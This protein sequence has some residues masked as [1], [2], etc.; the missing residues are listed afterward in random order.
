MIP[1]HFVAIPVIPLLP[2]GKIDR[3]AFP[4]PAAQPDVTLA[5]GTMPSTPAEIA[6]AAIWQ[7]LLGVSSVSATD[8]FFELGGHSLLAVRA[9]AEIEAELHVR[10]SP[11]QFIFETLAQMAAGIRS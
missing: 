3:K 2:N 9:I 8:N 11:R 5:V 6:I 4:A 1:Q 10:L 7:R